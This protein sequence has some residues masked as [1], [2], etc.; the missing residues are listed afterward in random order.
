MNI[1]DSWKDKAVV[2]QIRQDASIHRTHWQMLAEASAGRLSSQW[3]R[4]RISAY[5]DAVG[6]YA[7]LQPN[8]LGGRT[9]GTGLFVTACLLAIA[10][11]TAVRSFRDYRQREHMYELAKHRTPVQAARLRARHTDS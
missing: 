10:F 9:T 11:E 8:P 6:V 7:I 1:W 3:T 2:A 4:L 5:I